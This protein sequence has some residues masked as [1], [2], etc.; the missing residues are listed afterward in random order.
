MRRLTDQLF[1]WLAGLAAVVAALPLLLMM[2]AILRRGLPAVSWQFLTE[3]IRLVGAA[4]GIFYNLVGTMILIATALAVSAPVATGLALVQ[5]VYLRKDGAARRWLGGLLY[6]LNGVPSIL[7]GIFG[8]IVFVKCLSWGKSWLAGGILLGVM[9][10]PTVT[11]ALIERIEG[12][13]AKYIEAAAGLGLTQSQI[14]WS[15][16]LPQSVNGLVTG[17]LLGLARAAGETAPIMF[18]AT[19]FAG[20]T[21][22]TGIRESP[23]L[24]LPYHIFILA[25][26]SFDPAVGGK[27]WGTALVLLALVFG[28]SLVALPMRVKIHEEAHHG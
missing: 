12:L 8:L 1:S 13:P 3:Q 24:S 6:T 16:I 9:I 18:T 11:V 7:F 5:G 20:A 21:F 15:V 19:I 28:L 2:A 4:G 23:V 22:P 26:D 27:L 25:Q 10:L 14:I 17:S